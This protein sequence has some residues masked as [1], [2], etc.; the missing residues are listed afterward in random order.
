MIVYALTNKGGRVNIPSNSASLFA[1]E[2]EA[3]TF[4]EK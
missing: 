2:K 4:K 3:L 1:S